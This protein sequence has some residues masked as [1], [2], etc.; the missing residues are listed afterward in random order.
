MRDEIEVKKDNIGYLPA[1]GA[2]ATN[3]STVFE[4]LNQ[5]LKIKD[6]LKLQAIVVVFDQTLYAK[7]AEIKRKHTERFRSIVLRMGAF[8]AMCTFLGIIDKIFQDVGLNDIC[9]ESGGFRVW[10]VGRAGI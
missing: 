9:I 1:I 8:H 5:S 10:S 6:T 2:P 3:M 7:A 4:I